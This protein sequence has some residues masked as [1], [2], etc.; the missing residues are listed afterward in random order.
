MK[1]GPLIAALVAVGV[2][3]LMVAVLILPKASQVKA[4]Q[5]EV[6]AAEQQEA[7]LRLHLQQLQADAKEAPKNRKALAKLQA[8]VP[9]TVDLP[10]LI[11][12]LNTTAA[13]SGVD[14]M[15][16]TPGQPTISS[17]G[18]VSIIPATINIS[19]GF[20]AI[21]QYLFRLESLPRASKVTSIQVAPSGFPQLQLSLSV[22]FYTTD[23]SAGPGSAP[24]PTD[25]SGLSTAPL[26]GQSPSAVPP[27]SPSP[28]T[29]PTP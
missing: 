20:F 16:V 27:A 10:G 1:R 19:G 5:A 13:Q 26:P 25:Q 21:D 15:S 24:G 3:I 22:E 2:I 6:A 28:S 9:P 11:R 14:F 7:S 4:K 18:G 8:A 17:S 29:S 23:V 12:L